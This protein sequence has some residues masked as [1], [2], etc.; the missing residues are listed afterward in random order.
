MMRY[1]LLFIFLVS[2]S[3]SFGQFAIVNDKDN[4]LN[5]REEAT[6]NSKQ[7]DKLHNGDLIYCFRNKGNWANIDYTK[8]NKELNGYIYKD[9]YILVSSFPSFKVSKKSVNS[10]TLRKDSFEVTIF[11]SKF[12]KKK[13]KYKYVKNYPLQIELIDNKKYWGMDGGLPSTQFEKIIIKVGTKIISLPKIAVEG[14][15]EPSIFNAEVN[16]DKSNNTIYIQ[17][18]NSDGA[19][20][21]LVLWKVT[22]GKYIDRLV[23][24]GF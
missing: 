7:I 6:Q 17:T 24:Y 1:F 12:D 23:A 9:K 14:L 5:V 4:L 16:Y 2:F 20:S 11:Q 8:K 13:H 15:Y 10:I 21:Y 19:G 18:L 22:N 3:N